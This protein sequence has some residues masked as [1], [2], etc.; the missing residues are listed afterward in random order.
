MPCVDD[1]GTGLDEH[2]GGFDET[3]EPTAQVSCPYCGAWVELILDPGGAALQEYVEDCEICCQP[4]HLTVSW[5]GEGN[6]S[7]EAR[8]EDG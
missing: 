3:G 4:W 1:E 2:G 8:T 7:V 6:A 5:D